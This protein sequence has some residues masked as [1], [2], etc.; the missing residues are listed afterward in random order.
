VLDKNVLLFL[1]QIQRLYL[2]LYLTPPIFALSLSLDILS[3]IPAYTILI[4]KDVPP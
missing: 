2:F 1:L 3:K 4:R